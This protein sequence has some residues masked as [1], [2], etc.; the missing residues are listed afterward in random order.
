MVEN[1]LIMKKNLSM[2]QNMMYKCRVVAGFIFV[3]ETGQKKWRHI[4]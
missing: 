4:L 2:Y 3:T 1:C